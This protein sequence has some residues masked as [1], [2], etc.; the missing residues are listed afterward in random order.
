[1]SVWASSEEI[2]SFV[3]EAAT[4]EHT[5]VWIASYSEAA[6]RFA[7]NAIVQNVARRQREVAV[8]S[9]FGQRVGVASTTDLS[10]EGLRAVVERAE[11]VAR[12]SAPD[13][14]YLPPPGPQKYKAVDAYDR[15]TA[16]A[17]AAK[18]AE[19]VG[20]AVSEARSRD[21]QVSGVFSTALFD[22]YQANSAGLH[23][24]HRAT[25]ARF[26]VTC[27]RGEQ[28]GWAEAYSHRMDRLVCQDTAVRAIGKATN[29]AGLTEVEPGAYTVILEPAA[30]A[31][32]LTFVQWT[33]DAKAADEER[34]WWHGRLGRPVASPLLTARSVPD[35]P[36]MPGSPIA[37][38]GLPAPDVTWIDQGVL[39]NLA[40]SRYWAHHTGRPF[41]GDPV[42][43]VVSGSD[44]SLDELIRGVD[45]GILVTRFWYTNFVEEME[46]AITGMTRGGLFLI[47]NGE[48]VAALR[49]MRFN[50]SLPAALS[51]MTAVGRPVVT[52]TEF[53]EAM[54]APPVRIEG[55]HFTSG[56]SF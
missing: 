37:E 46:L 16:E 1:M 21:A 10:R 39:S 24:S 34:S 3:L 7:N 48:V 53:D 19:A 52:Y 6:T 40:Y 32:L 5:Q 22:E 55:F 4:A 11:D 41:T 18:R 31:G 23:A 49:N 29:A 26:A 56:T 43:L 9:A 36:D 51:R 13:E 28:S 38:D 15:P 45:R 44:S 17:S 54:L 2:A 20:S 35:H 25:A 27:M 14:E 33:L 8:R 47:E 42:N 50:E 30:F 12:N